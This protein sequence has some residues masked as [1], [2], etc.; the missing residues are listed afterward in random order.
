MSNEQTELATPAEAVEVVSPILDL[1]TSAGVKG[2]TAVAIAGI[3]EDFDKQAE[4]WLTDADAINVTDITQV[5]DMKLARESRLKLKHIRGQID[6]KRKDLKADSLNRGNAIQTAANYLRDKI[7]PIEA[8]LQKAEDFEKDYLEDL[9]AKQLV[10]RTEE[11]MQLGGNPQMLNLAVMTDE[12]F[13]ECIQGLKD[14]AAAKAKREADEK[15]AAEKAEAER[16]AK[17]KAER[18]EKERIKAENARLKAEAEARERKAAEEMAARVAADEKA[19]AERA[20]QA[21]VE[22]AERDRVAAEERKQREAEENARE[23]RRQL[24]ASR[25]EGLAGLGKVVGF[26]HLSDL[27]DEAYATLLN[28][29][30]VEHEAK[31]KADAEAEAKRQ[32]EA[33]EAEAARVEAERLK[34]EQEERERK[35]AALE[36]ERLGA[37]IDDAAKVDA[38]VIETH[39]KE[40]AAQH[41][42]VEDGAVKFMAAVITHLEEA[43]NIA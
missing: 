10:A 16:V 8:K 11:V 32:Q 4:Q 15:A 30:T 33:D 25:Q 1:V 3:F 28:S 18:E 42:E 14:M 22:Q 35:A 9:R 36:R 20:E 19:A 13:T 40:W 5:A 27:D 24:I 41:P 37:E 7:K 26:S 31:V 34:T 43:G 6:A 38:D 21:R 17:E 12:Q 39:A 2:E 29:A 23:E